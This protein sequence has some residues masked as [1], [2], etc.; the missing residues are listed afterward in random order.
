MGDGPRDG[1]L[2]VAEEPLMIEDSTMCRVDWTIQ[3]AR[4]AVTDDLH[5]LLPLLADP[6]PELRSM[7]AY[8]LATASGDLHTFPLLCSPGWRRET[9]RQSG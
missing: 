9:M 7:T 3:A 4:H 1:L 5:L 6:A 2:Q 8:V